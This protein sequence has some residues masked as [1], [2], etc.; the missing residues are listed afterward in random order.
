MAAQKK[1]EPSARREG[2]VQLPR[3]VLFHPGLSDRAVRVY[4]ALL[5]YAW[6]SR[7][8]WPSKKTLAWDLSTSEKT[9]QRG[10]A[11]LRAEGLIE[12]VPQ[13]DDRPDRYV[14]L[15]GIGPGLR[16]AGEDPSGEQAGQIGPPQGEPEAQTPVTIRPASSVQA[17]ADR[18]LAQERGKALCREALAR[19]RLRRDLAPDG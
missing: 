16:V 14:L 9:V 15:G 4:G 7:V 19:A 3:E 6:N 10:L 12:Q 18:R 11:E 13:G 2:F 5:S 1:Q 17:D 8:C